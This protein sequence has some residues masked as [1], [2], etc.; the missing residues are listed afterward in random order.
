MLDV[1]RSAFAQVNHGTRKDVSDE[2]IADAGEPSKIQWLADSYI[3][4]PVTR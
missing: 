2:S 1:N 4:V 3:T